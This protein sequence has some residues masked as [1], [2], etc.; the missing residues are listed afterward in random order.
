MNWYLPNCSRIFMNRI[1]YMQWGELGVVE[2]VF[3]TPRRPMV[4]LKPR[5]SRVQLLIHLFPRSQLAPLLHWPPI[6]QIMQIHPA[7]CMKHLL[8]ENMV[9]KNVQNPSSHLSIWNQVREQKVGTTQE[10]SKLV[11]WWIVLLAGLWS[12]SNYLSS[13]SSDRLLQHHPV[14]IRCSLS[15]NYQIDLANM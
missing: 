7:P 10:S 6:A 13:L 9:T 3:L 15:E 4:P 12:H 8:V 5:H 1:T 14:N 11:S 2:V